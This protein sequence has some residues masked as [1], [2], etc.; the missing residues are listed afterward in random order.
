MSADDNWRFA[1][2]AI[3]GGTAPD[4]SAG[5]TV[6]PVYQ[7]STFTQDGLGEHRG[8][9]YSRIGNPTRTALEEALAGL[10]GGVRGL[11]YASGMA[12][13]T[14]IVQSL[15]A[16][17]H[18]LVGDDLYGGTYRLFD[19]VMPRFG[20]EATFADACDPD[21]FRAALRPATRMVWIETPTNPILRV[22]DI[23]RSAEIAR[24][25]GARLVVDN[26]FATPFLQRP[27]D[28]GADAAVHSTTKY[29]GGHSDVIGGVT[30]VNDAAWGDELARLR[31]TTGGVPGPWDAW[32]ALRGL[33]TLAVRMRQHERNAAAVAEFLAGRPEIARVH[34]PG[35]PEHPGH[36]LAARQMAG[37]GGMVSADLAGGADAA[38]ALCEGTRLFAL[39]ESLGGV[40]SLIG[41]PWMMSHAAFPEAQRRE[42][43]IEA[44]TVRISVGLEDADDLCEDLGQ[45]LDR[46][47]ASR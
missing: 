12:A 8:F 15:S 31:N 28:L 11:A 24:E 29:I 44:S 25:A 38:K 40:H 21:A 33:K 3:H 42:K 34:Y 35:R 37:F 17:D 9:E 20:V 19:Q 30:V 27:L 36:A 22:I 6:T 14:G 4:A 16:G 1:T 32:L 26:T 7:T 13:I 39:A 23:A 43:G 46:I 47:A 18:V 10:E 41:Y 5:S 45:A 2:R